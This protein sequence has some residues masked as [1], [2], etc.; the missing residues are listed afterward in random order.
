MTEV[1]DTLYGPFMAQGGIR[2]HYFCM[3]F[4]FDLLANGCDIKDMAGFIVEDVKE[5]VKRLKSKDSKCCYC[6]EANPAAVC[7]NKSCRKRFHVPCGMKNNAL[8]RFFGAF[9]TFC[10]VHAK[11][12]IQR[13]E[14]PAQDA[15]CGICF[16]P[17][18]DYNPVSCFRPPCCIE[19]VKEKERGKAYWFHYR[20]AMEGARTLG[21]HFNCYSYSCGKHDEEAKQGYLD[22]GIYLPKR[23]ALYEDGIHFQKLDQPIADEPYLETTYDKDATL[24]QRT[25][26]FAEENEQEVDCDYKNRCI[27]SKLGKRDVIECRMENCTAFVHVKCIRYYRDLKSNPEA[28]EENFYCKECTANSCLALI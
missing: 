4:S 25:F 21:Y 6:K 22:H 13:D 11:R 1:D 28:R 23:D 12:M 24:F 16:D 3:L 7:C 14:L 17:L 18:G 10:D 5:S 2:C 8:M 20:C 19:R 9:E 15:S 27:G 26:V